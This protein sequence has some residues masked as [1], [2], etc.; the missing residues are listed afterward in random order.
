MSTFDQA[1]EIRFDSAAADLALDLFRA[2]YRSEPPVPHSIQFGDHMALAS[3]WSQVVA[4]YRFGDDAPECVGF[5]NFIRVEDFFLTGG[6]CTDAG[7]YRR[8]PPPEFAEC[9]RRGGLAQCMLEWSAAHL[10]GGVAMVG[11]C[12]D[13]RALAAGLRSGYLKTRHP[14]LIVR[15]IIP[16]GAGEIE[17]IVARADRLGPF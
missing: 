9:K 7:A 10:S 16:L 11:Y 1:L 15:P 13:K 5:V 3:D 6:L 8:L 2:A 4:T 12:G 17:R 14:L